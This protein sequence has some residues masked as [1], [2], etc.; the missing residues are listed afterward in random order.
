MF[1]SVAYAMTPPPG[2]E[3]SNLDI[4]MSFAPL[5]FLVVIF[6]FLIFRP[7]QK[8]KQELETMIGGLKEGD[9]IITTGGIYGTI[10]KIKDDVL[11]VQVAENVKIKINRHNVTELTNKA[12]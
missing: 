10:V 2:A 9:S 3:P 12:S 6:Y 1:P 8:R 11:T 4:I 7:Q 5:I